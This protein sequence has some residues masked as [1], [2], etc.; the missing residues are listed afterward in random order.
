MP[1]N[2]VKEA[3][4]LRTSALAVE[5]KSV[6]ARLQSAFQ[7]GEG[8]R[9]EVED[10]FAEAI[11]DSSREDVAKKAGTVM[12][13]WLWNRTPGAQETKRE[14]EWRQIGRF[15]AR[16]DGISLNVFIRSAL[17]RTA[18]VLRG[19]SQQAQQSCA[20]D[21]KSNAER[22]GPELGKCTDCLGWPPEFSDLS[23]S[24]DSGG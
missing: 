12:R 18:T 22:A 1:R 14:P 3:G 15:F 13:M 9:V 20:P 6:Y 11:T 16:W 10:A 23:R 17:P 24:V 2:N 4:S 5:Y 8:I 7:F 19:V 21:R